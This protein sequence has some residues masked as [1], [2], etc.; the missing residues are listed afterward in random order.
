MNEAHRKSYSDFIVENNSNQRSLFSTTKR[1]L[2]QG[3]EVPFP[4]TSDKLVLANEMG[5]FFVEKIDTI[6]ANLQKY[7]FLDKS[8]F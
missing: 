6:Q 2:N 7:F 1:L 3:H 8:N 5:R 4:P